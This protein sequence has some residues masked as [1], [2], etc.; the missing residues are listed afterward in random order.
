MLQTKV[1][2]KKKFNLLCR[3]FVIENCSVYE[4]MWKNMEGPG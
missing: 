4:L 2:K 3:G 1:E